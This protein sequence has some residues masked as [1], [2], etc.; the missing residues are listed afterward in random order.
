[1]SKGERGGVAATGSAGCRCTCEP[2]TSLQFAHPP[3]DLVGIATLVPRGSGATA[4]R[5]RWSAASPRQTASR[6]KPLRADGSVD[7]VWPFSTRKQEFTNQSS[8]FIVFHTTRSPPDIPSS[9]VPVR[10]V[11]ARTRSN[12]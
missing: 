9:S 11:F 7:T 8:D 5:N 3:H 1:M 2:K 12:A 6:L 10:N 4:S